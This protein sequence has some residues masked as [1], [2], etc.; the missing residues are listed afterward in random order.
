MN[1]EHSGQITVF[2]SL[3]LICVC[4]LIC[5][6]LESAR[7]AGAKC[8]LQTAAY[9]S[10]DSL[11]SQYHRKLWEEYRILGLE[12]F[13]EEA[14]EEEFSGFLQLYLEQENWFPFSVE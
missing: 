4:G 11:F 13:S 2:L 9:S 8:F 12:H 3:I 14:A 1:K 10:M 7:T 5:G 6:L